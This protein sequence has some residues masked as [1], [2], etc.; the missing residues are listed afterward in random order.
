MLNISLSLSIFLGP[1][2]DIAENNFK[3]HKDGIYVLQI[4]VPSLFQVGKKLSELIRDTSVQASG[5]DSGRWQTELT[6]VAIELIGV[7]VYKLCD[8]ME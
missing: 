2:L 5:G 1:F 3:S 7:R 4:T 8:C 6:Q